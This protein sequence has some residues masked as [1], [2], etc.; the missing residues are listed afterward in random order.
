MHAKFKKQD[1]NN[2]NKEKEQLF[3]CMCT[4]ALPACTSVY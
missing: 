1:N 2:N 4:G 3:Y